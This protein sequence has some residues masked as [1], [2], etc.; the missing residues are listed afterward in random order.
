M[1]VV[2]AVLWVG[3]LFFTTFFLIPAVQEAGPEGGKVMGALQRR[4]IMNVMPLL[5]LSTILSGIWLYWRAS[6]GFEPAYMRSR[7]GM[8][9][10]FGGALGIAAFVLGL[11]IVRPSM[12]RAMAIMQSLGS[13]TSD[14][15]RQQRASEAQRLRTRSGVVG[16]LVAWMLLIAAGTMAVARYL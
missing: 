15:E 3:M 10:G 9:F 1:H 11:T 6:L 5:A 12:M 7:P 2:G 14:E 4:G 8:A 16:Q 13:A